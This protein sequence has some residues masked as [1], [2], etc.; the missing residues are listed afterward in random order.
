MTAEENST[1]GE[2]CVAAI[3]LTEEQKQFLAECESQFADRYTDKDEEFV[4][5]KEKSNTPPIVDPWY[6]NKPR[7][8]YDWSSRGNP[9]RRHQNYYRN[10][11]GYN[12][13]GN[14]GGYHRQS[15]RY[16][17]SRNKPY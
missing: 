1:A 12:Q 8:N 5:Y 10:E 17:H 13:H 15:D 16:Y 3:A 4:K 11:R 7:R 14:G 9:G 2:I 6:N